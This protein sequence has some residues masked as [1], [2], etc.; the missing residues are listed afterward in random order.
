MGA[1]VR[2]VQ[3]E[4]IDPMSEDSRVLPGPEV[5]RVVYPAWEQ[6]TFWPQPSL[7]DPSVHSLLRGWCD[8]KLNRALCLKSHDGGAGRDPVAVTHIS[9]LEVH[10]SATAQFAVNARVEE[11][12]RYWT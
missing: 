5:A 11:R 9:N 10:E 4:V 2:T 12:D 3:A 7:L 6:E 8:F 1:V